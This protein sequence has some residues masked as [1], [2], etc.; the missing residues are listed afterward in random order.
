MSAVEWV[1]D[2]NGWI[3]AEQPAWEQL[4]EGVVLPV[5]AQPG[6]RTNGVKGVRN[7]RLIVAV[8]QAPERGKANDAVIEVLTETF[9]LKRRQISLISGDT[10]PRKRFLVTGAELADLSACLDGI[11]RH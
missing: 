5:L 8:T 10:N 6:S 1:S 2:F 11:L 3:M 4:V 7:G 9:G